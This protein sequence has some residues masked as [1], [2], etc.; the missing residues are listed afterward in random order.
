V[1]DNIKEINFEII[2]T[3]AYDKFAIK[4]FKVSAL[5]YL[6]KPI[7]KEELRKAVDKVL[8]KEKAAISTK[9]MDILLNN[10]KD[11]S[12]PFPNLAL[13]TLE[14]LEFIEV[15]NI[16]RCEADSNYTKFYFT[17]GSSMLV[18][19]TLR[20]IEEMLGDYRFCRPHQSHII[21]LAYIKKY[22]KGDGGYVVMNDDFLV[23]VSRSKKE[24]LLKLFKTR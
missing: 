4:A 11:Q 9:Q 7:D 17:D 13:P 18:S 1:L 16:L 23:S 8:Q 21:N 24:E 3:T 14:G 15:K 12:Q 20:E 5:D 6:L 2:F 19:K 10:L 22:I